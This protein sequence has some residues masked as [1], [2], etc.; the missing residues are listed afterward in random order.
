MDT[1]PLDQGTGE[2]PNHARLEDLNPD[3]ELT[4]IADMIRREAGS[5]NLSAEEVKALAQV[6]RNNGLIGK[7]HELRRFDGDMLV[8]V[9]A[10]GK[11]ESYSSSWQPYVSGRISEFKVPCRHVEMLRPPMLEQAWQAISVWLRLENYAN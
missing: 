1:Y 10:E 5:L 4:A 11:T 8:I 7:A 2:S 9:A 6:F 3:A